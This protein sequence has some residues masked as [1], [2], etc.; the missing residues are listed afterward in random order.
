MPT[1]PKAQAGGRGTLVADGG[2]ESEGS[3]QDDDQQDGGDGENDSSSDGSSP[4]NVDARTCKFFDRAGVAHDD[5][6]DVAGSAQTAPGGVPDAGVG[7]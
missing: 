4:L 6:G 2:S 7:A 5:Y 1:P 3:S